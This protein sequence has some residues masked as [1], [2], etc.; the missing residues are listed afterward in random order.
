MIL[1]EAGRGVVIGIVAVTLILGKPSI[2]LLLVA[3]FVEEVL[4]AFSTLADQRCVRSLVPPDQ[5]SNAQAQIEARTHVVVLAGRPLGVI[6]FGLA[7]VLPFLADALTF[8]ISVLTIISLKSRRV[9]SPG[10]RRVSGRQLGNDIGEGLSW[11]RRDRYA[12]AAMILSAGT[13]LIGQ[14]LIMI[15]LAEAHESR[16]SPIRIGLVLAASGVGGVLGSVVS[17]RLRKPPKVS[18]LL[19]QMLA[20]VGAFL[21]LALS[22]AHSSACVAFV[23]ATLSLGGALGNIE[24]STHL[25]QH[26]DEKMLA[27]VTSIGR[28]VALSACAVGPM[29]GGILIQLYGAQHAVIALL[30]ITLAFAT[31]AVRTPSIRCRKAVFPGTEVADVVTVIPPRRAVPASAT[32][33]ARPRRTLRAVLSPVGQLPC[34]ALRDIVIYGD[35]R[36]YAAADAPASVC[37]ARGWRKAHIPGLS[38]EFLASQVERLAALVGSRPPPSLGHDQRA[39]GDGDPERVIHTVLQQG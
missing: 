17:A 11:L 33:T 3:V 4:E 12:R 9:V 25:N 20:W 32:Q 26:V 29:L 5:A 28:L 1:S 10:T 18:L 16:L 24:I 23:M 19:I 6:L 31:F 2:L 7:P 34:D 39:R 38:E 22:S 13:T 37:L 36:S 27:R 8:V 14:A 15:F 35:E 30:A 21:I